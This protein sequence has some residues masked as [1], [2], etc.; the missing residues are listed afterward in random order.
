MDPAIRALLGESPRKPA[1]VVGEC[2]GLVRSPAWFRENVA[3][4]RPEC[5]PADPADR[6]SYEPRDQAQCDLWFPEVRIPVGL[7]KPRILPVLVMVSSHSRFATSIETLRTGEQGR[8]GA[9]QPVPGDLLPARPDLHL[10]ADFNAQL[11]QWLPIAN[12]RLV[13]RTGGPGT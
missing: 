13:R 7:G 10:P 2:V 6:I 5:A 1:A 4:S 3:R 9:R 12:A 11:G 8:G